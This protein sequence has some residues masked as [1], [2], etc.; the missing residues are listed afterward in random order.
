MYIGSGSALREKY[1][2]STDISGISFDSVRT[3]VRYYLDL[4][5]TWKQIKID[6][7]AFPAKYSQMEV[8]VFF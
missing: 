1:C 8:S 3:L 6:K 2:G 5:A 7:S 4:Y